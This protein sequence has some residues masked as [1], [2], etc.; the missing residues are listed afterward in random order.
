M[1]LD[2]NKT[3]KMPSNRHPNSTISL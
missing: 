3:L 2:C 1:T